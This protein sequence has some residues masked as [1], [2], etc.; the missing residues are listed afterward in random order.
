ML[1]DWCQK[2]MGNNYVG[3]TRLTD[4]V[5][6]FRKTIDQETEESLSIFAVKKKK[7][8][9]NTHK[10]TKLTAKGIARLK[11]YLGC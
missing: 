7:N 11:E 5:S 8:K 1:I 9:R 2:F 4:K 3:T 6:Q 10:H